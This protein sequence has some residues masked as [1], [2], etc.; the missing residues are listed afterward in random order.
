MDGQRFHVFSMKEPDYVMN[1]M[2]S[3]G[4]TNFV[5]GTE[6]K[7]VFKDKMVSRLPENFVIAN[8]LQTILNIVM[9]LMTT[10]TI[11]CSRYPLKKLGAPKIGAT[12]L[13]L[14]AWVCLVLIPKE[15]LK[16]WAIM[17][18]RPIYNIGAVWRKS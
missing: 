4:T 18:K 10:T 1:L 8:L 7:R 14:F 2:S 16:S 5:P 3:Y 11:V 9:W 12:V 15:V 6:T 17:K 13:L